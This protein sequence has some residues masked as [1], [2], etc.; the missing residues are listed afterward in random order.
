MEENKEILPSESSQEIVNDSNY[1]ISAI[2]EMKQNSVSRE[3]YEKVQQENKELINAL[4]NGS[5][6]PTE[7]D[8]PQI[9]QQDISKMR[10]ELYSK[11]AADKG[12][13]NLEYIEKTLEL[14]DAIISKG[15]IDPFLPIGKGVDL[16]NE[17]Y[18]A[19]EFTAQQFKECIEIADGNSE[20]FTAELMRRTVDNSPITVRNNI[21]RR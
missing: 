20:V 18:E 11:Q 21:Y 2:K 19:A 12:F 14:R 7:Q 16:T 17:D 5:N 3:Q 15:G 6:A 8:Q 4:I 1:Y 10:E 13:T 9:T